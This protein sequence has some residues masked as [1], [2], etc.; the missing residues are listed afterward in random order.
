MYIL[1]QYRL[2]RGWRFIWQ[3]FAGSHMGHSVGETIHFSATHTA[4]G[5]VSIVYTFCILL[6]TLQ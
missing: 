1:E 5:G 3:K 2:I 6:F 4:E